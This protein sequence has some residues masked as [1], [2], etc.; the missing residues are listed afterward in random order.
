MSEPLSIAP[1]GRELGGMPGVST[2]QSD[3]GLGIQSMD[4][5]FSLLARFTD[6]TIFLNFSTMEW[7]LRTVGDEKKKKKKKKNMKKK[8]LSSFLG[9]AHWAA[10]KKKKLP[11]ERGKKIF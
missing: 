6:S 4:S 9:R 1:E 3:S 7:D 5:L 11:F 8:I 10:R 2:F